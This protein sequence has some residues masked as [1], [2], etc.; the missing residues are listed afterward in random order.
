MNDIGSRISELRKKKKLTQIEL[1]NNLH[2]SDKTISSW[3]SN[4]TEPSLNDI[5]LLSE[6]IDTTPTYLLYGNVER[7]DLETEIKIKLDEKEFKY[8][9]SYMK[10]NAKF[11]NVVE[12]VDTYYNPKYSSFIDNDVISEWLR[13]GKRGGKIILNYKHWYDTYCDEYEVE[14]DD[15]K[16]MNRILSALGLE[17]MAVVDKERTTFFYRD[18]Y[19]V[20]LDKVKSLGYFIEIEVKD[21]GLEKD[22]YKEYDG[23]LKLAQDLHLDL[24]KIDKRGYPYY[25][26]KR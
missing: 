20:A 2:V 23:L 17:K 26:I 9:N 21:Y 24:N 14:I 11:L 16:N 13:I 10:T 1:G 12:Q 4:R 7:L 15:E 5:V 22:P 8:L 6:A 3:E 25:L 19:E 18:K